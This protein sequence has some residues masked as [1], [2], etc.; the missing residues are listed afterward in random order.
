MRRRFVPVVGKRISGP[1]V[2]TLPNPLSCHPHPE[3]PQPLQGSRITVAADVDPI[4]QLAAPDELTES[5]NCTCAESAPVRLP[6]ARPR[7]HSR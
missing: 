3:M 5:E 6:S 2:A 4:R 1:S 7:S